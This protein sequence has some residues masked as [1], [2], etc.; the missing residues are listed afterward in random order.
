MSLLDLCGESLDPYASAWRPRRHGRPRYPSQSQH[1][2]RHRN[3]RAKLF[4][5][6]RYSP[7][8][9]PIEQMFDK[10]KDR[11]RK[12]ATR[13]YEGLCTAIAEVLDTSIRSECANYLRNSG[14]QT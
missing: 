4:L 2:K 6:P 13:T 1:S 14:A 9:N 11:L 7:G 12:A 3:A 8:F 10:L 5:L